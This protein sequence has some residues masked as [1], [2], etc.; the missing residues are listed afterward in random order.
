MSYDNPKLSEYKA[1]LNGKTASVI[2][3][4]I[5]NIPLI[6]FLIKNNVKVTARDVKSFDELCAINPK[7]KELRDAG[8]NFVL[9][10]NYLSDIKEDIV[11]KSPG[12]RFDKE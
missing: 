5:S 7:V 11:Y 6:E 2:G 4:G 8:V 12:I 10:E 1:F 9:G 3:V